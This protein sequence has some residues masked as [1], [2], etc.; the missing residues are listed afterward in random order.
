MGC[1]A[2]RSLFEAAPTVDAELLAEQ[3]KE[4][5]AAEATLLTQNWSVALEQYNA[6]LK[7]FPISRFTAQAYFG[8][9][10]ALEGLGK[11]DEAIQVY[12][13]SAEQARVAS[14]E[15]AAMA[16]L[17]MSY[18][19]EGVGDET[20]LMAALAD[21][22]AFTDH[23]SMEIRQLEIPTRRAASLMRRGQRNE[24]QKILRQVESNMPDV[25]PNSSSELKTKH[26]RLLISLG[27]LDLKALTSETILS[28]IDAV[29][30][31]QGFLWKAVVLKVSPE[32]EQA[33]EILHASYL[34][35]ANMAFNPP[36]IEAGRTQQMSSRYRAELQKKWVAQLLESIEKLKKFSNEGFSEGGE[37]LAALFK[38]IEDN[39]QRVLWGQKPITPLTE[40]SQVYNQIKKEG[41]VVSPPM[42]DAEKGSPASDPVPATPPDAADP[43][44]KEGQP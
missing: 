6:F 14:P 29:Q 36:S 21:A 9:G 22:E 39:G 25:G 35:L 13:N 1:Q 4:V 10:R 12:R 17:R 41:R 34:A 2:T 18:C 43:N 40:E 44:L 37:K 24:A 31:L 19:Y 15:Q 5:E 30:A 42:F 3:R 33:G 28:Y 26:V 11:Y 20:R 23:L 38:Q 27:N 8:R 7:R 16:Y 32:S